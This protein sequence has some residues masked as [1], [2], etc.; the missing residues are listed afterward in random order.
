MMSEQIQ[1]VLPSGPERRDR[2]TTGL[3][4]LTRAIC[5]LDP[6]QG[7]F[8]LAGAYG[9]G[10]L[11]ENDVFSMRPDYQDAECDCGAH[12]RGERWHEQHPH[13]ADCFQ[14]VLQARFAKYDEESGYN[15]ADAACHADGMMERH[16]DRTDFG[17]CFWSKRTPQGEIAHEAWRKAHDARNKAHDRLTRELYQERGI[18]P[19]AY[20]WLCTC[21][22]D[23]AA[24]IYFDGD[25]RHSATC[26]LQLPNFRHKASGFEVRW[27]KWIGRDQETRGDAPNH[28]SQMFRECLQSLRA[29]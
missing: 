18:T 3:R 28:L 24:K 14:S 8:G 25:G 22:V 17:I 16:E 19:S 29:L 7:G 5:R 4:A 1:I 6:T 26:A 12:D 21:G 2:L 27:Y 23:E 10:A 11:F 9:Y 15:A 13:A 20:Q